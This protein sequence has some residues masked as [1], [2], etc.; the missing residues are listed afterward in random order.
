[1]IPPRA[2]FVGA[3]ARPFPLDDQEYFL[4]VSA[5]ISMYPSN[6]GDIETLIMNADVAMLLLRF[7]EKYSQ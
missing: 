3:L 2:G 4:T 5:G 1:M 7:F 6:P